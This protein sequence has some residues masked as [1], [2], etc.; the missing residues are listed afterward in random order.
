MTPI[1]TVKQVAEMLLVS[2]RTIRRMCDNNVL[3]HF[4]IGS[5]L[6]FERKDIENYINDNKKGAI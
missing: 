6:R 5:Q 3:P 2:D 1:L 4:Y